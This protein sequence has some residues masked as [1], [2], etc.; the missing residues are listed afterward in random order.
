MIWPTHD[1]TQ[2]KKKNCTWYV[3]TVGLIILE[4]V[5]FN[6]GVPTHLCILFTPVYIQHMLNFYLKYQI[7]TPFKCF[8]L[9]W[10]NRSFN[11]EFIAMVMIYLH[12]KFPMPSSNIWLVVGTE[13]SCP[14]GYTLKMETEGSS[15]TQKLSTRLYSVTFKYPKTTTS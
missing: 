11:A 8:L 5:I 15:E 10:Q 9:S 7:F 2:K 3:W 14:L 13:I 1:Y 4:T 12:T 6:N